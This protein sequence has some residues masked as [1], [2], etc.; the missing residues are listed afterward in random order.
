MAFVPSSS[1][2]ILPVELDSHA[3]LR[4]LK[5]TKDQ[6][7]TTLPQNIPQRISGGHIE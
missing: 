7:T 5:G 4:W 3:M 6:L 2:L 1:P